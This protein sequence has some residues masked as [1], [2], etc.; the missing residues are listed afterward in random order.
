MTDAGEEKEKSRSRMTGIWP[1]RVII[2]VRV[3]GAQT[4]PSK[5][6]QQPRLLNTQER[7]SIKPGHTFARMSR[8][9]RSCEVSLPA[10][11]KQN[12]PCFPTAPFPCTNF[13][14][15]FFSHPFPPKFYVPYMAESF[16]FQWHLWSR[17][18]G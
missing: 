10:C 7:C 8:L 15:F 9:S 4:A 3:T 13:P 11:C 5:Q 18:G 14:S 16:H 17:L 6:Q 12:S 1:L 2:R